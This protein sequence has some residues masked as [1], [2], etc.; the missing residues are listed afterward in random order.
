[1]PEDAT[2]RRLARR[3]GI[4]LS[5]YPPGED[6]ALLLEAAAPIARGVCCEVGVGSGWVLERLLQRASG[7]TTAVGVD[8]NPDAC[9]AT[10]ARVGAAPE[11]VG[12]ACAD[13]TATIGAAS[14]DTL[15]CNPPY[16]PVGDPSPDDPIAGAL[17]AGPDGLSMVAPVLA[18]LPRILRPGGHAVFIT[19]GQTD[20][21]RWARLL[22][23]SPLERHQRHV[24]RVGGEPLYADV[25][26]RY[27]WR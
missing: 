5:V 21:D 15:L 2:R 1:M 17:D 19:S 9:A 16:L 6:S 13:R 10:L 22:A 27:D 7:V 26:R 8:R 3:R 20:Q 23:R 14:V 12:V 24:R 18:D 25:L 4:S 11:L